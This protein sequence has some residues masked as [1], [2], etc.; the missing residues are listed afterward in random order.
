MSSPTR[1]ISAG[2]EARDVVAGV[3]T[4]MPDAV[5]GGSGSNGMAFLLTVMPTVVEELLGLVAGDAERRHVHE[6]EVVVRAARDERA[7]CAAS[8]SASTVAFSMVRRWSSR[9]A[10]PC[11]SSSATALAAM[12]CMS[13]PPWIP[14][15][16]ALS[17]VLRQVG[18]PEDEAAARTAQRLVGRRR[19]D[20]GVRER[21]GMEPGRDEPGDVRHVHEQQRVHAV[22]D[23]GHALEVD[24]AR[25]GAGA[26]DDHARADL[27][28]PVAR[29]RRSRCA[30]RPRATP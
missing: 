7:P 5:F 17:I 22:R 20:V 2:A 28:R 1:R 6:H 10:S 26:H 16:T 8:V 27:A 11:A 19:D 24:D 30:R 21:A 29:A 15:K 18:A 12:T 3:P 14:G 23:A 9:N 13:G 4:R 25:V